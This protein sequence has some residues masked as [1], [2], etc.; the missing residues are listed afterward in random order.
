[1]SKKLRANPPK[2][3]VP[4]LKVEEVV[5]VRR[6]LA[7][8]LG[9]MACGELEGQQPE[10]DGPWSKSYVR[11]EMKRCNDLLDGAFAVAWTWESGTKKKGKR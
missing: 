11:A 5:A 1:M 6:A 10:A 8:Y 4:E 9:L 3:S 2:V 7:N